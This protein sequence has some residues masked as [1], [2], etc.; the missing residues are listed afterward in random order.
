M[1]FRVQNSEWRSGWNRV[2]LLTPGQWGPMERERERGRGTEREIKRER[3]PR[4][5]G[6]GAVEEKGGEN[7]D[8]RER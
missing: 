8:R 2:R 6:E 4:E 3:E 1:E 5:R 7:N